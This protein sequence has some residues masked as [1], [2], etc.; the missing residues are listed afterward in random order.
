MHCDIIIE[1][2]ISITISWLRCRII[3]LKYQIIKTNFR[4]IKIG[5]LKSIAQT[6]FTFYKLRLIIITFFNDTIKI[7]L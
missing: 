7:V 1:I 3:V 6:Y 4:T 5:L 2:I